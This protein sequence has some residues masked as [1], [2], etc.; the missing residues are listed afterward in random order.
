MLQRPIKTFPLTGCNGLNEVIGHL[1]LGQARGLRSP[2]TAALA[3]SIPTV[4]WDGLLVP[5]QV[6][7]AL[8]QRHIQ[9]D[10]SIPFGLQ[11]VDKRK[12]GIEVF[13]EFISLKIINR[14]AI[15]EPSLCAR[16]SP[17]LTGRKVDSVSIII[18]IPTL[19]MRKL[20]HG[21]RS[22]AG[23]RAAHGRAGAWTRTG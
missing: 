18:L 2:D 1:W 13:K 11:C 3:L 8:S 23:H 6:T 16:D 4:S 9:S 20:R 21:A 17:E 22:T 15:E 12:K 10:P 19:Q 5:Y 14:R 7:Q